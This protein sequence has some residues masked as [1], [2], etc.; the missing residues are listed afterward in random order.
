MA[1]LTDV[2]NLVIAIHVSESTKVSDADGASVEPSAIEV[3]ERLHSNVV[4]SRL[5]A[6]STSLVQLIS[7]QLTARVIH[8][9]EPPRNAP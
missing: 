7:E 6:H 4:D 2:T 1:Q 5:E 8:A 3:L 9:T